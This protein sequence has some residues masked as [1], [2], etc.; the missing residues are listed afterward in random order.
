MQIASF[1]H[2]NTLSCVAYV[3]LQYFSKL[4][5]KRHDFQG[6]KNAEH[7]TCFDFFVQFL[8]GIFLIVTRIQRNILSVHIYLCKTPAALV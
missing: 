4:S 5:Y 8:S 2:R 3:R 7:N 1:L 6:G